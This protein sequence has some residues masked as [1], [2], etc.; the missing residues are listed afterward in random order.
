[1]HTGHDDE[2]H[3]RGEDCDRKPRNR[4]VHSRK[5]RCE[6]CTDDAAKR[7]EDA[8]D[9][10]DADQAE[11]HRL[12]ERLDKIRRDSVRKV[13]DG[14][15]DRSH[16]GHRKHRGGV[17]RL[18]DRQEPEEVDTV[19]SEECAVLDSFR[20]AGHHRDKI[21]VDEGRTDDH[22]ERYA[23]VGLLRDTPAEKDREEVEERI[24]HAV[25]D[26]VGCLG[27]IHNAH[28]REQSE[29]DLH[30]TC[31]KHTRQKRGHDAC[32]E[33]EDPLDERAFRLGGSCGGV[34]RDAGHFLEYREEAAHL[35]SDD[36]LILAA[37]LDD[38]L[39]ALDRLDRLVI[40]LTLIVQDK[41][42]SRHAVL[43]TRDVLRPS[44][45]VENLLRHGFIIHCHMF[46]LLY[47][48][49]QFRHKGNAG[50]VFP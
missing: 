41:T 39:D 7:S 17:G 46:P 24:R 12:K 30:H 9:D 49:F 6:P 5:Y 2:R 32:D 40:R 37:L 10:R 11:Q 4:A 8:Y 13:L 29:E 48:I 25:K 14:A 1:M 16:E 28:G 27:R 26:D 15:H 31:S 42:K 3:Q 21:R 35:I 19:L 38:G 33:T 50:T 45:L 34:T 43:G 47:F 22:E 36:D 23:V 20:R 18:D 44:D